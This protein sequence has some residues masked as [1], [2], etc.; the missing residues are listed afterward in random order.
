MPRIITNF[1]QSVLILIRLLFETIL[2]CIGL[3]NITKWG[4]GRKSGKKRI[5]FQAY[6]AHLAQF[7]QP[8]I[9]QLLKEDI[10]LVVTDVRVTISSDG[11]SISIENILIG[12][13]LSVAADINSTFTI[14]NDIVGVGGDLGKT[15]AIDVSMEVETFD[16]TANQTGSTVLDKFITG[17]SA[18][19]STT[20][21]Q[22]TKENWSLLVG[23]GVCDTLCNGV[24]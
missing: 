24:A 8:V 15:E 14:G 16:V 19:A 23:E 6:A 10:E 1:I 18:E 7:Y 12:K 3:C 20:L 11:L 17:V 13:V 5:A 9:S 22:M 21:L 2:I 4:G